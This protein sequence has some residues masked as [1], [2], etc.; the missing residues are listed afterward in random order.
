[1][2]YRG[3]SSGTQLDSGP[4]ILYTTGHRLYTTGHILYTTR[5]NPLSIDRPLT[6]L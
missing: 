1:M 2:A 4:T 5:V 6:G 3:C